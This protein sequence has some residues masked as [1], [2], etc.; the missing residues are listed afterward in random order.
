[1]GRRALSDFRH[2]VLTQWNGRRRLLWRL[3][4]IAIVVYILLNV[5]LYF[6]QSWIL[7]PAHAFQGKPIAMVRAPEQ[8]TELLHLT[9]S[10]GDHIVALFGP[11]LRG[12]STVDPNAAKRPTL[13]Y[14]YGNGGSIAWSV[15]EFDEARRRLDVNAIMPEY[16]GYGMSDGK[17]T[18]AGMYAA[19]DAA[20]DVLLHRADV[21]PNQIFIAGWSL[22]GGVAI[23]LASR[24]PAQG[25]MV[26]DT[27]TSIPEMARLQF[28]WMLT[29]WLV[30]YHFDNLEKIPVVKCPILIVHGKLDKLVPPVMSKRLAAAARTPVTTAVIETADHNTIFTAE[31]ERLWDVVRGFMAG[32]ENSK[33]ET[34]N[35]KEIPMTKAQM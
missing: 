18:E 27:F 29:T 34:R 14:C 25:L 33:S 15:D 1:M 31:P 5:A 13:L 21:D 24:K 6:A 2:F 8:N 7:F 30:S 16:P 10:H 12:D 19:A 35:L 17:P 20:Y 32:C 3:V 28:P 26:F 9:T 22:G 4:R 23:D 11:A